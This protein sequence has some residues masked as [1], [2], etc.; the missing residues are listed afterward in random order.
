MAAGPQRYRGRKPVKDSDCLFSRLYSDFA[1]TVQPVT[2]TNL[3]KET[4]A[5]ELLPGKKIEL[6]LEPT[7][8]K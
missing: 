2:A 7:D 8:Q 3:Q 5:A 1:L 4:E 6:I